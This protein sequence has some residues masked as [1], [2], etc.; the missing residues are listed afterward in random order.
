MLLS[1]GARV[2]RL[3]H[4]A[5]VPFFDVSSLVPSPLFFA[6]IHLSRLS[7]ALQHSSKFSIRG[8][9]RVPRFSPTSI[10]PF[11]YILSVFQIPFLSIYHLLLYNDKQEETLDQFITRV[12]PLQPCL[13]KKRRKKDYMTVYRVHSEQIFSEHYQNPPA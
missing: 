12:L 5:L 7:P 8:C 9:T 6:T 11:L 3:R 10:A 1:L 13:L 2:S 4:V